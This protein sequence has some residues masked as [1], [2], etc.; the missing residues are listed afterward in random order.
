[1]DKRVGRPPIGPK[2]Q[3][4]I[5]Q[6]AFDLVL[7]EVEERFGRLDGRGDLSEV[8]RDVIIDGCEKRYGRTS[9]V[10]EA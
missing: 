4:H 7:A 10:P 5:P 6:G 9:Y 8:L 3:T 1:M 2:V